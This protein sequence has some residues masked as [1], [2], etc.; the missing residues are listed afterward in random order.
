MNM[1]DLIE[2]FELPV[3]IVLGQITELTGSGGKD[4]DDGYGYDNCA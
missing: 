4:N 3:L 1:F 2:E